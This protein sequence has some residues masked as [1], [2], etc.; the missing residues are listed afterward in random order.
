MSGPK[1][2]GDWLAVGGVGLLALVVYV[3]SLPPD[4]HNGGDCGEMACG[5]YCLG[6]G[7]P[8]G[9]PLYQMFGKLATLLVPFGA[10]SW[11][12]CLVSAVGAALAVMFIAWLVTAVTGN[13]LAGA[14]AGLVLTFDNT[15]F[16]QADICEVYGLSMAFLALL[17]L[18]L[19]RYGQTRDRRWVNLAGLAVGLGGVHHISILFNA[20]AGLLY[21]ILVCWRREAVAEGL[22]EALRMLGRLAGWAVAVLPIYIYLPI[23]S[24]WQPAMNWGTTHTLDG[25]IAHI[26]GRMYATTLLNVSPADAARFAYNHTYL[27]L[28]DQEWAAVLALVGLVVA[29]RRR[30]PLA[31]LLGGVFVTNIYFAAHYRVG[32]RANYA[33]PSHVAA[34]ALAGLGA[35]WLCALAARVQGQALTSQRVR[36]LT[37][38]LLLLLPML[39]GPPSYVPP[40]RRCYDYAVMAGNRHAVLEA[41]AVLAEVASRGVLTS[42]LDELTNAF[43]YRQLVDGQRRDVTL[44]QFT[45]IDQPEEKAKAAGWVDYYLPTRRVFS[46]WFEP[47]L[48]DRFDCIARNATVELRPRGSVPPG[49]L[50]IAPVG[51]TWALPGCQSWRLG[52]A[53]VDGP[54]RKSTRLNSSH[55]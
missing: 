10:I 51:T 13:R 49:P 31:L 11:R 25:F 44:L 27:V 48:L 50:G 12:V 53:R 33:L 43:W 2:R 24:A 28:H 9:Y 21:L 41:D 4:V 36:A 15:F 18:S 38:V 26:T 32:D 52:G 46:A 20:P 55:T 47:W 3:A 42:A 16:G 17:L 8:T 23:R 35:A 54:D 37:A 45:H 34:A 30:T 7:H 29:L 6:V 40:L 14:C 1:W 5:A 22:R 19:T 39:P